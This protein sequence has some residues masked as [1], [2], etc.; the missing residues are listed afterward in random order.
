MPWSRSGNS[1]EPARRAEH[2]GAD[3]QPFTDPNITPL[4][5]YF[6]MKGYTRRIGTGEITTAAILMLIGV[7]T[8]L[9]PVAAGLMV[10]RETRRP[11]CTG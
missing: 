9:I 2:T 10:L 11:A 5:K 1:F 8:T 3:A 7:T 6:W 4:M